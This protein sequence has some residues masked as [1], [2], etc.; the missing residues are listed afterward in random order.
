MATIKESKQSAE[1]SKL[2]RALKT[3]DKDA[4]RLASEK[5]KIAR[6]LETRRKESTELRKQLRSGR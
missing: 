6:D 5:T 2:S 1:I 3:M 4:D